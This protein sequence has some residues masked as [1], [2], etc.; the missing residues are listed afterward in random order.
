MLTTRDAQQIKLIFIA[1]I[2]DMGRPIFRT[3]TFKDINPEHAT[4]E[5]VHA[6]GQAMAALSD[7][8]ID[9][10]ILSTDSEVFELYD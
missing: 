8:P 1:G 5:N 9:R 6:F 2:N 7:W 10:V 4:L 3:R